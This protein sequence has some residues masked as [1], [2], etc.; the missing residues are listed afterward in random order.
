M[1][2]IA[3]VVKLTGGSIYKYQYFDIAKDG[4]RFLNDLRHNVSRDIIFDVMMRVRTSSGIRPTGFY[5]SFYMQ[6]TTDIEV[7]AIDSDKS[8]QVEIKY[9]DK[10]DEKEPVFIQVAVLFTSVGGQR[11]LRIHNLSLAVTPDFNLMYRLADHNTIVTHFF[12]HC[13]HFL[14]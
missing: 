9:D 5:G 12:K 10:L 6:N 11:R 2:S 1:A 7:S 3:P 14:N 8:I 4:G 13:K